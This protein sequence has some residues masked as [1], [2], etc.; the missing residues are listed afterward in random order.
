MGKNYEKLKLT[1]GST[2]EDAVE[3]LLHHR[4]QGKFVSVKFNDITLYSDTVT[5]DDA[6]IQIVGKTKAE[7]D[8]SLK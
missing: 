7:L 1:L 4:S 3:L 5:M 6:Y 8:R 2:I